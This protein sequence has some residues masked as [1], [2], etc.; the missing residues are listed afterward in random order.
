M[1]TRPAAANGLG[2]TPEGVEA[3]LDRFGLIFVLLP[4]DGFYT[5]WRDLCLRAGV[6]GKQVHDTRLVAVCIAAGV[7][8]ILT[9]NPADFVRFIPI[10][11]GLIVLTPDQVL[12]GV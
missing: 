10:V 6:S 11:P 1:A 2:L 3:E 12:A 4:E 8:T 9:W 5:H 7:Q